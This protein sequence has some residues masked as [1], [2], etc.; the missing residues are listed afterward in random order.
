MKRVSMLNGL[1]SET[2]RITMLHRLRS[3]L[4]LLVS[5]FIATS[6]GAAGFTV[7]LVPDTQK[8]Q[9]GTQG[10]TNMIDWII[11]EQAT[12][13][14]IF[15]AGLGDIVDLPY[16]E[17]FQGDDIDVSLDKINSV[18]GHRLVTGD[19]VTPE[20]TQHGLV[21]DQAYWVNRIDDNNF[22]IHNS[23][24][25]AGLDQNRV[26]L[27]NSGDAIDLAMRSDA[28][29]ARWQN[30]SDGYQRL[31]DAGIPNYAAPGNHDCWSYIQNNISGDDFSQWLRYWPVSRQQASLDYAGGNPDQDLGCEEGS[32]A[33]TNP[34]G[35]NLNHYWKVDSTLGYD[36]IFLGLSYW[37]KETCLT[38]WA[39]SIT[40]AN[41]NTPIFVFTHRFMLQEDTPDAC[42]FDGPWSNLWTGFGQLERNVFAFANGHDAQH[43]GI[44]NC[45]D[46]APNDSGQST[47][48]ML[49]DVQGRPTGVG[50]VVGSSW[51]RLVTFRNDNGGELFVRTIEVGQ[52]DPAEPFFE[53][54]AGTGAPYY[55]G[56]NQVVVPFP[57][58]A[59]WRR[60]KANWGD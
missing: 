2:P 50:G 16:G 30:I 24:V 41:P 13:N 36:I 58:T 11:A 25:D 18:I 54:D 3:L 31:E 26:D 1:S 17:V 15:V 44:G 5:L 37:V 20:D 33:P 19:T 22:S 14:I 4:G 45:F 21:K 46:V 8:I 7:V 53:T 48:R 55:V 52:G 60:Q 39:Q 35:A 27:I 56:T 9:P 49:Y 51:L 28:N 34:G 59:L 47:L 38:N 57:T 12:Y 23:S 42:G 10:W 43:S 29:D 32:W 6:S 40:Q